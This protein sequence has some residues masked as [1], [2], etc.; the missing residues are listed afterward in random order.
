MRAQRANVF[1]R[2]SA[3]Q[4]AELFDE[5][6]GDPARQSPER[7]VRNRLRQPLEDKEPPARLAGDESLEPPGGALAGGVGA[8][9]ADEPDAR[10]ERARRRRFRPPRV[11]A[12]STKPPGTSAKA[13]SLSPASSPSLRAIS[14]ATARST[15]PRSARFSR[16]E[17][18]RSG[19]KCTP[20]SLPTTWPS[21]VTAPSAPMPPR[22]GPACWC[23]DLKQRAGAPVDEALHQRLM[24][25]V[26]KPVL[27]VARAALPGRPDR[28]ASRRGWRYRRACGRGRAASKARRCRRRRG[29]AAENWPCIQSSGT[30]RSPWVRC[31]NRPPI[32]RVCSSCVVLRKSGVWQASHSRLRLAR[33]RWRG[34]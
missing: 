14:G 15:A 7:A 27:E 11:R 21:T 9:F 13:S 24:Q 22:I 30:R 2:P 5:L 31:S 17:S 26:G 20:E 29:R 28:R 8:E 4:N 16:A 23:S 18:P 19:S 6:V 25:G 33:S 10:L 1:I 3:V 32:S 34:E 12:T